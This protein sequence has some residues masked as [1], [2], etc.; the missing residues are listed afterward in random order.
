MYVWEDVYL[1]MNPYTTQ[2]FTPYNIRLLLATTYLIPSLLY[3]CEL[4]TGADSVSKS[5]RNVTYNNIARYIYGRSVYSN[6]SHISY[7]IY[8]MSLE[9]LL[10]YRMLFFLHKITPCSSENTAE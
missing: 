4:F 6:I 3:C 8:N 1:L 7:K 10:K 5:K 9:N 2:S